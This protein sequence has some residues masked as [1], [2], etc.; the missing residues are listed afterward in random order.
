MSENNFW[1]SLKFYLLNLMLIYIVLTVN[2]LK[3]YLKKY[4]LHAYTEKCNCQLM[5]F[6]FLICTKYFLWV[7]WPLKVLLPLLLCSKLAANR[8]ELCKV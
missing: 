7:M 6:F 2:I 5:F 8:F 3:F 4:Y 1:I